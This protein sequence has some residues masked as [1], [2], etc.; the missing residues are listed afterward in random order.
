MSE[1]IT[2]DNSYNESSAKDVI[3]ENSSSLFNFGSFFTVYVGDTSTI[4]IT[5]AEKKLERKAQHKHLNLQK[6]FLRPMMAGLLAIASITGISVKENNSQE[7]RENMQAVIINEL[8]R[9]KEEEIYGGTDLNKK[10]KLRRHKPAKMFK[11][12]SGNYR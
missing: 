10:N 11:S 1:R 12:S 3:A 8:R 7:T 4:P 5:S 9:D 6:H 2:G